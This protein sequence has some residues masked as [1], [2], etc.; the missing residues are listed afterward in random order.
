M[1]YALTSLAIDAPIHRWEKEYDFDSTY[2]EPGYNASSLLQLN[3]TLAAN[4]KMQ[5]QF[6]GYYVSGAEDQSKK[7]VKKEDRRAYLCAMTHLERESYASC[8]CP[9]TS[10]S[11]SPQP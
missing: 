8:Y 4:P 9:A 3:S 5:D 10:P 7:S 11:A 6:F 2:R 1:A